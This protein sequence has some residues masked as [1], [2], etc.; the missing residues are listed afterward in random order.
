MSK[1][2]KNKMSK[3]VKIIIV[4]LTILTI[5]SAGALTIR[6]IYLNFFADDT[7]TTVVPDNLIGDKSNVSDTTCMSTTYTS[8]SDTSAPDISSPVSSEIK[9]IDEPSENM[10]N[11][12][13]TLEASALSVNTLN[14]SNAEAKAINIK[15]YKG[16][17]SDNEKFQ[18]TNMLPG[19]VETKYFAVNVSHHKD[20]EI[21][22]SAEVTEQ[23]KNLADVLHIKVT[24]LE[25]GKVVYEGTFADTS[26]DGYG[27]TFVATQSTETVA[28]YKIEVSLPTSTGNEYQEASLLADFN[29]FVKDT[30]VLEPPQTGDTSGIVLWFVL[31]VSSLIMIIILLFFRRRDKEEKY[32]EE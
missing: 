19:D 31:M 25:S 15:L 14:D 16:H 5:L 8:D 12:T 18:A 13:G 32:A 4:T 23:T 1:E 24:H 3:S 20:V 21:F 17:P 6:V 7:V 28:Y 2:I 10:G 26:I 29:W 11:D 30:D 22:F 9:S 27:E